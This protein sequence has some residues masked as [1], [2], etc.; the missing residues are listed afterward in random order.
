[1]GHGTHREVGKV[2]LGPVTD[3]EVADSGV[4]AEVIIHAGQ[5]GSIIGP[6]D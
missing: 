6:G 4:R 2:D 1:M 3:R 5:E